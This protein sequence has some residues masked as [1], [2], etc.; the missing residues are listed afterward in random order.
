[1]ITKEAQDRIM[2]S[3]TQYFFNSARNGFEYLLSKLVTDKSKKILMPGYIGESPKEGSGVFD[4]IRKLNLSYEFYKLKPDLSVDTDDF[5][6]KIKNNNIKVALIIH[7]FG[8][9]QKDIELIAT[10]CKELD[11]LLIE[12]CAHS[13]Q[14]SFNFIRLGNF[15][16]FSFNSI[17]KLLATQDGGILQINDRKFISLFSDV[18]ENMS[19]D[20]ME[21]YLNT[22]IIQTSLLRRKNYN[23]YLDKLNYN[24]NLFEILYPELNEG[25]IPL[26]FP[27]LIKNYN[28]EKYYYELID[29]G[30]ITVSLYYQMISEILKE[31][32]PL[33]YDISN[34]ILNLPVHQDI[35]EA[36]I[37]KIVSVLN[38]DH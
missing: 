14:S 25:V 28:R 5:F 30:V 26:N 8:F 1:M 36:D 4:P 9:P 31:N 33:S 3:N 20:T 12:D 22:D 23:S 27:I 6:Y 24:S 32:F 35:T 11:I 38:N 18:N 17:H 7:Y 21:I 34:R 13:L 29:K 15:G 37:E 2:F 10:K 16:D 19:K